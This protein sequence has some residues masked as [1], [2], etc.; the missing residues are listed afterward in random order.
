MTRAGIR[1]MW[2]KDGVLAGPLTIGGNTPPTTDRRKRSLAH[3]SER[4]THGPEQ[5]CPGRQCAGAKLLSAWWPRSKQCWGGTG[6]GP[7]KV[8]TAPPPRPTQ[9]GT[10]LCYSASQE[11]NN[12]GLAEADQECRVTVKSPAARQS[13]RCAPLKSLEWAWLCWKLIPYFY[14]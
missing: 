6:W 1:D 4:A 11:T 7:C 12:S 3:S 2:L 13:Q 9:S 14:D 5:G 8:P 10:V